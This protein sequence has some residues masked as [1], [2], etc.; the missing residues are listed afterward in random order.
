MKKRIVLC[1][2]DYGQAKAIS[3]AI[4]SLLEKGR[5][6]AASC[7]V[8]TNDWAEHAQ[9]LLPF[10]HQVDLGLHFNLTQGRALSAEYRETHGENFYSLTKVMRLALMHSFSGSAIEA[11][12][13]AQID[14]FEQALGKLPDHL[15]GH[16]HVHQF[17]VIREAVVRVYEKRLRPKKAYIRLI[18]PS[19]RMSDAFRQFK[20]IIVYAMGSLPMKRLLS[21][22]GIPHNLSF[23]G[24]YS[25]DRSAQYPQFFQDFLQVIGDEGLIM[26]HPGFSAPEGED[27][28]ADARLAEYQ[29]LGSPQF[30]ED[31]EAARVVVKRFGEALAL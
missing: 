28:I 16:Q 2:D 1:A 8:N 23:A 27:L 6:S 10:H 22:H 14:R 7:M 11:E 25:F 26:C 4:L 18:N 3:L 12:L 29:Y 9:W 19:F 20:K 24:I 5:L 21:V 31:C 15:D 30:V 13:N 17:P